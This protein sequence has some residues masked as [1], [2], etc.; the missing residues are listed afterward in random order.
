MIFHLFI[1]YLLCI[2]NSKKTFFFYSFLMSCVQFGCRQEPLYPEPPINIPNQVINPHLDL[3][4]APD[5]F[6]EPG[7]TF[8]SLDPRLYDP[9]R[10]IR[11]H[12]DRAAVQPQNVQPLQNVASQELPPWNAH[13][14]NYR[15]ITLG[16]VQTEWSAQ[17]T[18]VFPTPVYQIPSNVHG[19]LF[20]DPMGSTKP[21]YLKQPLTQHQTS[22][23]PYTFDQ[24]TMSFREDIMARQSSRMDRTDFTKFYS[25]F[26]EKILE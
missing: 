24:D 14:R 8:T 11:L 19:V 5:F 15:D 3:H 22:L 2:I 17:K 13:Y 21:Y 4:P 1:I 6:Q 16:N 25:F 9:V 26:P 20:E 12:F 7:G 10:N 23:S 18:Q